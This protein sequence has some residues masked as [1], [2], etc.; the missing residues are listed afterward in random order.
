VGGNHDSFVTDV[1]PIHRGL[2][3]AIFIEH[4]HLRDPE[5]CPEKMLNG[6]FWTGLNAAAELKGVGD[7]AKSVEKN[8]REIFRKNAYDVNF[9]PE[10][11]YRKRPGS[12]PDY[13]PVVVTG[14]TH[15]RYIALMREH[16]SLPQQSETVTVFHEE[17][18]PNRPWYFLQAS[19]DPKLVYYAL[20]DVGAYPALDHWLTARIA[21]AL[22]RHSRKR[23]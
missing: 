4:G 10:Y 15:R 8:R 14:H 23:K 20:R 9:N 1:T 18:W 7:E 19:T 17:P 2:N 12:V 5:N 22:A 13:F 6:I 3:D 16:P 11:Q 21:G